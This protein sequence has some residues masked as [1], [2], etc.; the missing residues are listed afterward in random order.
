VL[1]TEHTNSER[2]YLPHFAARLGA[3]CPG[4]DVV[5]SGIDRDPLMVR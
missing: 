5:V 3:L 2:G 4:L 1:L